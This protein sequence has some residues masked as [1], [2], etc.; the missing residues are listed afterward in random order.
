MYDFLIPF[1][2]NL[3]TNIPYEELVK[4]QNEINNL[5]LV[6]FPSNGYQMGK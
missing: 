5:S 1:N 2:V 4:K 3:I 6:P